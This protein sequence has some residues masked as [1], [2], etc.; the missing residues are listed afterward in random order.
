M[1][2]D[3]MLIGQILTI[4]L[5]MAAVYVGKY[6]VTVKSLIKELGESFTVTSRAI[7][8][9][10]VTTEELEAIIKEWTDVLKIFKV[11]K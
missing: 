2:I 11:V 3:L 6:L 8:D 9:G 7:E 1:E 10:A 4:A 5:G